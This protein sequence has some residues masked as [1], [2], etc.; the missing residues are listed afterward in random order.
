MF[1]R[2]QSSTRALL[3]SQVDG[4]LDGWMAADGGFFVVKSYKNR[5]CNLYSVDQHHYC[6]H[7]LCCVG[8]CFARQVVL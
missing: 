4:W 3:A 2:R 1:E 6:I 8:P 5:S 7:L